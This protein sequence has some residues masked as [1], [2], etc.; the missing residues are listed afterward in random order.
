L[1]TSIASAH[2]DQTAPCYKDA[3]AKLELSL[4]HD[5][6][7]GAME[8]HDNLEEFQNP[9]NYDLEEAQ[10]IA[11][12][13]TFYLELAKEFG[14]PILD[15]A[16]GTG[17]YALPMAERGFEITGIDLA[18]P[19]LEYARIK[20]KARDLRIEFIHADAREFSLGSKFQFAFMTGNAFQMFLTRADQ[21]MLLR[22]IK[23]NLAPNGVFA[24]ETRNPSGHDLETKLLEE[25]WFVYS[26]IDG[27]EVQVSGV[28]EFDPQTQILH[29]TTFRRLLG[30]RALIG[31]T[32][33]DCKF[34][35]L[36]DVNKLLT[37]NG[38]R[39]IR[40]YGNWD[41]EAL[42]SASTNIITVCRLEG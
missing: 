24:F 8:A 41:K 34:T 23:R 22:S 21:D 2:F 19:M 13:L 30:T 39:V 18:K 17:L 38:L 36:E 20:A 1:Q 16:C 15:I 14:N 4:H 40:Q 6:F 29:W 9:E 25:D 26:N 42:S 10:H 28:Q 33:I 37:E 32:R 12:P 27:Q 7:G 11:R 31:T 3:F 35:P 5:G